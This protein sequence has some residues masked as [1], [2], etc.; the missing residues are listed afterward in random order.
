LFVCFLFFSFHKCC[1]YADCL[2]DSTTQEFKDVDLS[3]QDRAEVNKSAQD[4]GIAKEMNLLGDLQKKTHEINHEG[5][6]KEKRRK[7]KKEKSPS[8]SREGKYSRK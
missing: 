6:A 4:I 7:E 8:H 1:F 3:R 2:D 5:H